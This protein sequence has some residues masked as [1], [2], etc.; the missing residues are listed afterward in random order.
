[1]KRAVTLLAATGAVLAFSWVAP[2]FAQQSEI[3][4]AE[5]LM[6]QGRAAEAYALLEP[7]ESAQAGNIAFDYL[8]GT[9]ALDSGHP[10]RATIAFERVLLVNPNF[11]GARLDLARAYFAMGSDDLA[12]AELDAVLQ[13][14]PPQN[15]RSVV[16]RYLEAIEQRKKKDQPQLAGYVEAGAGTD[17]NITAVTTDFTGAVLQAYNFPN[18]QPTGNSVKREGTFSQAAAGA[19]YTRPL[20]DYP[21]LAWYAGGDARERH[22]YSN[23]AAFDT[24]QLDVRGGLAYTLGANLFK[25]GVQDQRYFQEGAAPP[26]ADGTQ[27]TNDRKTLGYALEWRRVIAPGRQLGAFAQFNEQ[28]FLTNNAQDI[29]QT[30]YGLQ[31]INA[32]QARGNPLVLL[33][34]FQS[35]DRALRPQNVAGTTDV[36]KTVTGA[37]AYA[38]YTVHEPFDVFASLGHTERQDDS[39]FSRSTVIG[40]GK[41][42]TFDVTLGINWRFAPAWMLRFQGTTTEN[43]SNIALYEYSRTELSVNLR[44]DFR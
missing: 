33:A 32:F 15:V 23:N 39:M 7:L 12:K 3:P 5:Q 24:Q 13:A 1:M 36:S 28:R 4:R 40:Y 43:R 34:L 35:R 31:L 42:R 25:A 6:K 20:Q 44:R 9:A 27:V 38:Q 37:R 30:L 17:S 16:T 10:D 11:A 18:V 8:F 26:A 22:Y 41:D 21:G 2:A 14:N 29:D 19:E